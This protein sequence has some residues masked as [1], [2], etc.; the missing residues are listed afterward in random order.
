MTILLADNLD[1]VEC[2]GKDKKVS[3]FSS[4]EFMLLRDYKW[5][6][7]KSPKFKKNPSFIRSFISSFFKYF[8]I[9]KLFL[10]GLLNLDRCAFSDGQTFRSSGQCA[11]S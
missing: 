10:S 1:N 2:V 3:S 8:Y 6:H 7:G 5:S 11:V 4:V 9:A